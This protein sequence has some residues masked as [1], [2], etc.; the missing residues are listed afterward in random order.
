M[1][2]IAAFKST[3]QAVLL[4]FTIPLALMGGVWAMLITK[5]TFNVSSL[6]GFVA[7]FGL[8]VQKGVILLEYIN[9]LKAEGYSLQD[10]IRLAGKTRLRPVLMTAF[11]ASFS[12]LPLALGIGAGAEIQQPMAIVLIGGLIVSTPVVLIVLPV[13]YN[14]FDGLISKKKINMA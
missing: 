14:L 7:H 10:A 9:D 11:A 5:E 4:I 12:V 8:T 1:L 6:I 3:W 13:F 2:L